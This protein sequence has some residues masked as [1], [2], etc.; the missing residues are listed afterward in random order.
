MDEYNHTKAGDILKAMDAED[1]NKALAAIDQRIMQLLGAI[2]APVIADEVKQLK[3]VN[4]TLE[5]RVAELET[6]L[7]TA[8]RLDA[9]E[10]RLDTLQPSATIKRIA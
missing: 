9:I 2:M 5:R 7:D 10:Q 6:K 1:R 3:A 8:A 4:A